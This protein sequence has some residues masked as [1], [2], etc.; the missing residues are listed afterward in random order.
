V[1]VTGGTLFVVAGGSME[2]TIPRG[3]L[4]VVRPVGTVP[5]VGDAVTLRGPGGTFVTH[6]VIRMAEIDGVA[7][8]ELRGDANAA[9]DPVLAP[10]SAVV[11]RVEVVVPHAGRVQLALARPSGWL[12]VLGGALTCWL[13][14]AVLRLP[15]ASS[16]ELRPSG[17]RRHHGADLERWPT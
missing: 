1:T 7:Y 8:L 2:P 6:R 9:P 12:V 10:A 11:G 14:G 5:S 16:G 4:V 17:R 3:S 13:A 15:P